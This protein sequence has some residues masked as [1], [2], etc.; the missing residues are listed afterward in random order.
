[1][2]LDVPNELL[3]VAEGGKAGVGN[4]VIKGKKHKSTVRTVLNC[5]ST[6]MI[7]S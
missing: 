5:Y 2:R 4:A 7:A 6:N 3:L 1:M